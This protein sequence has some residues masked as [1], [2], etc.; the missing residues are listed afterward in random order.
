M[1][2]NLTATAALNSTGA[3]QNTYAF[4]VAVIYKFKSSLTLQASYSD[5]YTATFVVKS[6]FRGYLKL[7]FNINTSIKY[8]HYIQ[9]YYLEYR[10]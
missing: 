8:K 2:N 9:F 3:L 10:P 6:F 7:V 1:W 5:N 4:N